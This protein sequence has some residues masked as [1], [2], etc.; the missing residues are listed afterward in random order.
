MEKNLQAV[1]L[2]IV[3]TVLLCQASSAQPQANNSHYFSGRYELNE[4]LVECSK[5]NQQAKSVRVTLNSS[6]RHF[7][8]SSQ[9]ITTLE[10]NGT[11]SFS[12][13]SDSPSTPAHIIC[14][15]EDKHTNGIAFVQFSH[16]RM[17]NLIFIY[18]GATLSQEALDKINDSDIHFDRRASAVLLFNHCRQV[19][20]TN[21]SIYKY[22]GFAVVGTN[23]LHSSSFNTMRVSQQNNASIKNSGSGVLILYVDTPLFNKSHSPHLTLVENVY[24]NNNSSLAYHEC[25][26]ELYSS[27]FNTIKQLPIYYAAGLTVI[28][29]Q[30]TIPAQVHVLGGSFAKNS[31]WYASAMLVEHLN[32]HAKSITTI[33]GANFSANTIKYTCHGS[34]LVFFTFFSS[35]ELAQV[36]LH[37]QSLFTST[38]LTVTET[39]FANHSGNKGVVYLAVTNQVKFQVKVLFKNVYFNSNQAK[40]G[41]GVCMFA[42]IYNEFDLL[43]T[44]LEVYLE[45][46]K[47]KLTSIECQII[48]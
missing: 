1:L 3:V 19:L 18:C 47:G 7:L 37:N 33:K 39:Q 32:S 34:G 17:S 43:N 45:G 2:W 21:I 13:Q 36:N 22:R 16:V 42:S 15:P 30:R 35:D 14:Q 23:I 46:V 38:L 24:H 6:V 40:R 41:A 48:L 26:T 9:F 29:N 20:L 8:N 4:F 31:G 44:G 28:Y 25:Q 5:A 12:I 27:S 11:Q 10:A